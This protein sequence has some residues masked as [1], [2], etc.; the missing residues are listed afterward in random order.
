MRYDFLIETYETERL[1]VISAWSMFTDFTRPA[2]SARLNLVKTPFPG[3][4]ANHLSE[5]AII[6][7]SD[8]KRV[9]KE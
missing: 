9:F 4:Y 5:M 6:R 7:P 3:R 1:K 2:G 8:E